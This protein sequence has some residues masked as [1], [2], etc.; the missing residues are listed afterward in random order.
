ME[1]MENLE[2]ME[3]LEARA[4]AE[5]PIERIDLPG[6]APEYGERLDRITYTVGGETRSRSVRLGVRGRA[7]RIA[8]L[9]PLFKWIRDHGGSQ[10][11]VISLAFR[12]KTGQGCSSNRSFQIR[13]GRSPAPDWLIEECCAVLGV[14][15]ET[16]YGA[17]AKA[18]TPRPVHSRRQPPPLPPP[19]PAPV[20]TWRE[21]AIAR[22]VARRG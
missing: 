22:L 18:K 10:G 19:L 8:E 15:R 2:G 5:A 6:L 20:G 3:D 17:P 4:T 11:R 1:A 14:S 21:D 16:I 12:R 9:E 13:H 7:L